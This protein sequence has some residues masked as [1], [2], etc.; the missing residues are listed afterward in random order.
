MTQLI[1]HA[2]V[3]GTQVSKEE[4]NFSNGPSW[5][6]CKS[7]SPGLLMG[8]FSLHIYHRKAMQTLQ[9]KCTSTRFI[10]LW[11]HSA[12][13]CSRQLSLASLPHYGCQLSLRHKCK[14]IL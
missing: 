9:D 4:Q 8:N 7:E 10:L 3:F 14:D 5:S 6:T 2:L 13:I 11:Q 1:P 12:G